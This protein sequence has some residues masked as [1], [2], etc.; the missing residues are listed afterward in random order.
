MAARTDEEARQLVENMAK[1]V[2]GER[3]PFL[4]AL[5][6]I[7]FL[8][9]PLKTINQAALDS[10]RLVDKE[11]QA[12]NQLL[13]ALKPLPFI[14]MALNSLDIVRIP[15]I[16]LAAFY[17]DEKIPFTLPNNVKWVYAATGL[18]LGLTTIFLPYTAP[19]IAVC[20][21]SAAL[22]AN[23]VILKS[24]WDQYRQD[25]TDMQLG[26]VALTDLTKIEEEKMNNI[27]RAAKIMSALSTLDI[28]DINSLKEAYDNQKEIFQKAYNRQETTKGQILDKSV[29]ATMAASIV[30]G[31]ILSLLAIPA[32][33]FILIATGLAGFAYLLIRTAITW[34]SGPSKQPAQPTRSSTTTMNAGLAAGPST[35]TTSSATPSSTPTQVTE[36]TNKGPGGP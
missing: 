2:T 13:D 1:P 10:G 17:L 16:Y 35:T 26:P 25:K 5:R 23:L 18:A 12:S 31:T 24:V 34:F 7:P 8:A 32:A 20:L 22:A 6:Y 27:T 28:T 14:G 33:P 29:F 4:R 19:I 9:H 11:G 3:E 30:A 36:S 15:L 21:A